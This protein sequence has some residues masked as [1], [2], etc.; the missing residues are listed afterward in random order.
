MLFMQ[1]NYA[2]IAEI[3]NLVLLLF[4]GKKVKG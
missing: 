3:I 2:I 4:I 1:E